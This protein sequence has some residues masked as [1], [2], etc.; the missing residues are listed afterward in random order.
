[1][2]KKM[3]F[4]CSLFC[5]YLAGCEDIF[6]KDISANQ[7]EILSPADNAMFEGE[8]ILFVWDM[9]EGAERYHITIVSPSFERS[10]TLNDTITDTTRIEFPLPE[11]KYQWSVYAYNSGYKSK[12]IVRSFEIIKD[13]E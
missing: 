8:N 1:M 10:S 9:M 11:G 3:V 2:W 7:V 4:C 6:L 5:I 13:D 12:K